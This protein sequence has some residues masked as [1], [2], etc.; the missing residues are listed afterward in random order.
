MSLLI[1]LTGLILQ[2]TFATFLACILIRWNRLHPARRHAIAL[3]TLLL[4]LAAP[5]T[6]LVMPNWWFPGQT[7]E[8]QAN[9]TSDRLVPI[10]D[11]ASLPLSAKPTTGNTVP[12]ESQPTT[13]GSG[14][15]FDRRHIVV[16]ATPADQTMEKDTSVVRS[17]VPSSESSSTKI[18]AVPVRASVDARGDTLI[19]SFPYWISGMLLAIWLGGSA[20]R[21]LQMISHRR[22]VAGVVSDREIVSVER[23]PAATRAELGR[24][25]HAGPP[26]LYSSKHLPT[27]IVWCVLRPAVILPEWLLNSL[28]ADELSGVL[29]HEFAHIKRR[30]PW[31]HFGQQGLSVL[32][33]FH[34]GVWAV[35]AA[36]QRSR[37]ELCDNHVLQRLSPIRFAQTLLQLSEQSAPMATGLSLLG[38]F[39]RRWSL[40]Q[41]VT[42]LLDKQR[43]RQVDASWLWTLGVAATALLVIGL[44][45]GTTW[46]QTNDRSVGSTDPRA[47]SPVPPVAESSVKG[48]TQDPESP[49]AKDQASESSATWPDV[50]VGQCLTDVKGKPVVAEV[51]L[52]LTDW[53]ETLEKVAT[54]RCDQE[55][56]F[57]LTDLAARLSRLEIA[58]PTYGQAYAHFPSLQVV[59]T[60]EGYA[61]GHQSLSKGNDETLQ[62]IMSDQPRSVSGRV[63]DSSGMPVVGASVFSSVT[64][65]MIDG[66]RSSVTDSNGLYRIEDLPHPTPT[67]PKVLPDGRALHFNSHLSLRVQAEGFADTLT[68]LPGKLDRIDI[69]LAYLGMIEG[70]VVDLMTGNSAPDV[71]VVAKGLGEGHVVRQKTAAD[72][73][74]RLILPEDYYTVGAATQDRVSAAL[75]AIDVRSGQRAR[76]TLVSLVAGAEIRGTVV[77]RSG[78]AVDDLQ[79]IEVGCHGPGSPFSGDPARLSVDSDGR[80]ETRVFPGENYFFLMDGSASETV[81]VGEGQT[82]EVRL[83]LGSGT[84][85]H[86]THPDVLLAKRLQREKYDKYVHSEVSTQ[87]TRTPLANWRSTSETARLLEKLQDVIESGGYP[88]EAWQV[89]LFQIYQQGEQ[90][91]P[92]L[93]RELD[94]TQD[95]RMLVS[96]CFVLRGIGDKRAIPAVI[97]AFPKSLQTLWGG[98]RYKTE[99]EQ[100]VLAFLR[101]CDIDGEDEDNSFDLSH[102]NRE[103]A[104]TLQRLSGTQL[105]EDELNWISLLDWPFLAGKTNKQRLALFVRAAGQWQQ[106]W[107]AEGYQLVEDVSWRE[108]ELPTY[109]LPIEVDAPLSENLRSIS[110]MTGFILSTADQDGEYA[111]SASVFFDLDTCRTSRGPERWRHSPWS[112]A[113]RAEVEQWA[114]KEGFD[115]VGDYYHSEEGERT[116]AIRRLGGL[117]VWQVESP[118]PH[119][120]QTWEDWVAGRALLQGDWLI[121][122]DP[123]TQQPLPK[124][125]GEFLFETR[126][127]MYGSIKLGVPVTKVFDKSAIGR[128]SSEQDENV[129][130]RLGRKFGFQ[131]MVPIPESFANGK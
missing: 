71:E 1:Y 123:T 35:N 36:L 7:S 121:I 125:T 4:V 91:V 69:E 59:A 56:R 48:S 31:V 23:L 26:P 111:D 93:I 74:F 87:L 64:N 92:D 86:P 84:K 82:A 9:D 128:P 79:G 57:Q 130:F 44:F 70:K 55:G 51:S 78:N 83:V 10:Q 17:E 25:F 127:G 99:V 103:V 107:E 24:M 29:I 95:G 97:R 105:M 38:L 46:S 15:S 32:W 80:F 18:S 50:V 6:V 120:K 126:E 72:G 131:L 67:E 14:S 117:K 90:A 2:V 13:V 98:S 65:Q 5:L 110:G 122:R 43:N 22:V 33:W 100:D 76:G 20:W 52:Y 106:W 66:Y 63:Q 62:L 58:L 124:A 118:I 34:P 41:R 47:A 89:T 115:L 101:L 39:G 28:E 113:E 75:Q 45:G 40:E 61:S 108:F 30:D 27:P 114:L 12:T 85:D 60:A 129:G 104:R 88:D 102:P 54:A 81:T 96:I 109:H 77:D 49:V 119:A 3:S 68:S 53:Q 21:L 16:Q 73:S 37:E 11:L 112:T 94:H 8:Q 42:D 116:F 19:G